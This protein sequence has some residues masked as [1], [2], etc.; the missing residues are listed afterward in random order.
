MEK[1]NGQILN[2]NGVYFTNSFGSY[3][4][5]APQQS[6]TEASFSLRNNENHLNY[7]QLQPFQLNNSGS[8]NNDSISQP[9]LALDSFD[10]NQLIGRL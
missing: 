1:Q 5:A 2:V 8:S 6:S 9:T 10:I 4:I 7:S 3:A